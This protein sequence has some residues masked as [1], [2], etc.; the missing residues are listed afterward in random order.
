MLR[1]NFELMKET[2][3]WQQ[4]NHKGVNCGIAS[5]DNIC[6]IDK[7]DLVIVLARANNGKSTFI[8]YYA[9]Q[10][11]KRNNWKFAFVDF[12][13]EIH[14][15][16]TTLSNWGG[17]DLVNSNIFFCEGEF[18]TVCQVAK[19]MEEAKKAEN[20]D[21]FVIDTYSNLMGAGI[22][23][24][25]INA[26][27]ALLQ[28]TAKKLNIA[29]IIAVHPTKNTEILNGY[30]ALGSS[31]F[32]QRA[33][34]V[35]VLETNFKTHQT[36]I[37]VDKL[38]LNGIRGTIGAETTLLFENGIYTDCNFEISQSEI[39]SVLDDIFSSPISGNPRD[40]ILKDLE[41][42]GSSISNNESVSIS[43]ETENLPY[44]DGNFI[45][46][47]KIEETKINWYSTA[48]ANT[49]NNI[50]S[51][52]DN[53]N[54][55]NPCIKELRGKLPTMTQEQKQDFKRRYI[56]LISVSALFK[57]GKGRAKGNIE[58]YTNIIAID[59][60]CKDNSG[61]SIEEMKD[62]VC[63]FPFV[64]YCSKSV[65]GKG[66][67]ALVYIDGEIED[68]KP[69]FLSLQ[70]YFKDNGITI[71]EA[72]K[73]LTRLRYISQDENPYINENALIYSGVKYETTKSKI[74][75]K[76]NP[77]TKQ[78]IFK[79]RTIYNSEKEIKA[80]TVKLKMVLKECKEKGIVLNPTHT[81]TLIM[82]QSIAN[83]LG[84]NGWEIFRGF[85]QIKHP[86]M[87]KENAYKAQFEKD[88]KN[89]TD[90]H[91]GSV[92]RIYKEVTGTDRISW[93]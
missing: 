83:D 43:R 36:K 23:T 70:E 50:V 46:W 59:I 71:D 13:N 79:N 75:N 73:D 82:S 69:H 9:I 77:N 93:K 55:E 40:N 52:L 10:M 27:L 34:A 41:I 62:I 87:E 91:L 21:A 33:D 3:T 58:T 90:L 57:K 54:N 66:L 88:L 78:T 37:K 2:Q 81:E 4:T 47:G 42:S 39:D 61:V 76:A 64:F 32:Q 12:E 38:R 65:S 29:L 60:D 74:N 85:L 63:K 17:T 67:F 30:S 24:Y 51:L 15:S 72:C 84:E 49:N 35:L 6:R 5:L 44:I 14:Q 53:L 86:N 26:D 92:Y 48:T 7:G 45:D 31:A 16:Y 1:N 18:M 25:Q 22:D 8:K 68:F 89:P 20:I 56:P 11:A 28:T 80:E 19:E